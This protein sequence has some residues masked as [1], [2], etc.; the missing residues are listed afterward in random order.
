MDLLNCI[1]F[2]FTFCSWFHPYMACYLGNLIGRKWALAIVHSALVSVFE[3]N[4][5]ILD[6]GIS[7]DTYQIIFQTVI[8]LDRKSER[9]I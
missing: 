6:K 5:L 9:N 1:L 4:V 7:Y 3:Q 2:V 8:H